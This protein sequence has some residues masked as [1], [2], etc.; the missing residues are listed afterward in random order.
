MA[1]KRG[2]KVETSFGAAS[3]TDLMFLLLIFLMVVTTMINSNAL[4]ILLPKS[5]NQTEEKPTTTI[6]V[7]SDLTY[8]M[9]N[10]PI[11]FANLEP[12]L[13]K[14]FEGVEKPVIMLSMDKRVSIEEF[15]KLMNIAKANDYALFL[16]TE[17]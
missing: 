1:I 17:P 5:A 15:A 2:S 12:T 7:T 9:D 8:Y 10:V 6:S 4:K 11:E 13:Q 14:K 16:M 3:M